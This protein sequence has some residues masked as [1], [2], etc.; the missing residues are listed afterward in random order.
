M[1]TT[2]D[3]TRATDRSADVPTNGGAEGIRTPDLLIAIGHSALPT[4]PQTVRRTN[5]GA[6]GIRTPDLLIANETRYQLR[7]SPKQRK[8]YHRASRSPNRVSDST[9]GSGA[10]GLGV[11]DGCGE[12]LGGRLRLGFA[13]LSG[14]GA[15]GC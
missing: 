12:S 9:T 15:V 3:T 14:Q 5:G 11:G 8:S 6:E 10:S 13:G 1:D 4:A 7:H 2:P